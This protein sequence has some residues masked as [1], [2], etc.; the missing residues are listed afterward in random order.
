MRRDDRARRAAAG[1]PPRRGATATPPRPR[2]RR[3]GGLVAVGC[4]IRG[5]DSLRRQHGVAAAR[6][7]R[8]TRR[9]PRTRRPGRGPASAYAASPVG[10]GER[11]ETGR[12]LAVVGER[13]RGPRRDLV[14]RGAHEAAVRA[15]RS[16]RSPRPPPSA[17]PRSSPVRPGGRRRA[18]A[19]RSRGRSSRSRPCRRP[20]EA[21]GPLGPRHPARNSRPRCGRRRSTTP[22]PAPHRTRP[23][24]CCEH[25]ASGI[26]RSRGRSARRPRR[27][28]TSSSC[29]LSVSIRS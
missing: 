4:G 29:A 16:R 3:T 2:A 5:L 20:P 22:S 7:A 13:R 23:P 6:R 17:Q 1:R 10:D 14:E 11:G 26:G 21:R 24:G 12:E 28:A 15:R 25:V 18:R 9:R 19:R 8:L 27:A